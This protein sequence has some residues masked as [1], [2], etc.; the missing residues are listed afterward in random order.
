[1]RKFHPTLRLA[2]AFLLA[3]APMV[4]GCS[5]AD[6]GTASQSNDITDVKHTD[7]ERQSIG[8]CW[9]YAEASW[10]ESM[11]L[12]ATGKPFDLS[13]SYWT[14]WHWFDQ[15]TNEQGSEIET[16][17][18]FGVARD[19]VAT[20]G[21]MAEKD[22]VPED[23]TSEMSTRQSSALAKINEELKSGRLSTYDAKSDPALVRK[24]L[25][26]AWQLSDSVKEQLTKVFGEDYSKSFSSYGGGASTEGTAVVAAKDFPV[27]YT[28]R[29]KNGDVAVRDATLDK[30]LSTWR[31]ASYP[32]WGGESAKRDFQIRVQRSLHDAQPVVITWDVDFNAMEGWDPELKGSF[33]LTTLKKAGKPGRQGGHMTVLEDYE[34]ITQ[35]FGLLEA[36]VTLDPSKPEDKA[37]LDAALL[38]STT[39]KFFRIKNSWGALRD[40]RAS[41]PGFPGYHDL[42]MDYLN[43]PIAFC[44]DV[45]N[46]TNETCTGTT[47]PLESVVLPPGY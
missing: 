26:E 2:S 42:Y 29:A 41:A 25:D 40:D 14:Y 9:L 32:S 5:D 46:P 16:G 38:K 19:I 12:S 17:G 31:A 36:G 35:D 18:S 13:Q 15:I 24:V 30:A 4:A 47:V 44:P 3:L 34:A 7:V 37:K 6:T 27:Q 28:E 45:K 22:F 33:N 10:I 1:M 20:R 43:G 23:G 11:N 8:N 39:I 21:L